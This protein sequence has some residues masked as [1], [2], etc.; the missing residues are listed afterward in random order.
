MRMDIMEASEEMMLHMVMLAVA[1]AGVAMAVA[2]AVALVTPVVVVAAAAEVAMYEPLQI[3]QLYG[4]IAHPLV[5]R[6]T[7]TQRA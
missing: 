1:V 2:V 6:A 4:H 7:I 3:T 5:A